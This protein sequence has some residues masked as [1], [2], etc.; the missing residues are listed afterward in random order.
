VNGNISGQIE[1]LGVHADFRR[2]GLARAIL[3][4][5][6]QRLSARSAQH[7]YV[8]T[9]NYRDAAFKLYE[10]VGFHVAHDILMYRKDYE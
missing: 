1:P 10:S 6:L 5:G 9:D 8:Q 7:I 3:S 4:E 2:L